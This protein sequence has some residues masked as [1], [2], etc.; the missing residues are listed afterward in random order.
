MLSDLRMLLEQQK[1]ESIEEEAEAQRL[2]AGTK[3]AKEGELKKMGTLTED[4]SF[5]K[6]GIA[7]IKQTP[8]TRRSFWRRSLTSA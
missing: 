7:N 3:T 6:Q 8:R 4:K 2:F 1:Q 5:R